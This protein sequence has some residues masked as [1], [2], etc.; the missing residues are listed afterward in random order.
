[1]VCELGFAN[2]MVLRIAYPSRLSENFMRAYDLSISKFIGLI[3]DLRY[4]KT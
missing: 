1:M 2:N 3:K 4:L